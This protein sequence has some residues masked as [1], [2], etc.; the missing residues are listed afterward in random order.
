M[1]DIDDND[2][3]ISFERAMKIA[4]LIFP[5]HRSVTGE[6]IDTAFKILEDHIGCDIH[7]YPS[8]TDILTWTV[9]QSWRCNDVSVRHVN[10]G[11]EL[12]KFDTPLRIASHSN[13]FSGTLLGRE[14]KLHCKVAKQTHAIMHQYRYYDD[15]WSI[16]L[17][18]NE[19]SSIVDEDEYHVNQQ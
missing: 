2:R 1:I 19:Y 12:F 17:T 7:E 4:Q 16:S 18:E 13:G 10:T 5:L 9:P 15:D 11:L 3:E 8:F 6:G 14:L